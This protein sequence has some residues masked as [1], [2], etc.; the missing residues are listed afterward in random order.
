MFF[1]R[2]GAAGAVKT[3][4]LVGTQQRDRGV[5]RVHLRTH[6]DGGRF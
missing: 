5:K 2:P 3:V 4:R 1:I 6:G